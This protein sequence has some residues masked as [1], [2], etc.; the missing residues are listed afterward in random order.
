MNEI[1]DTLVMPHVT[2]GSDKESLARCHRVEADAALG[3]VD[4]RGIRIAVLVDACALEQTLVCRS[5]E[6]V[7][8]LLPAAV[9]L[10]TDLDTS[11]DDLLAAFE[12]YAELDDIAIVDRVWSALHAG[13]REAHVV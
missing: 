11:E 3:A 1:P 7:E 8:T 6:V 4:A 12:V 5:I 10:Y 2:A 13:T 9:A